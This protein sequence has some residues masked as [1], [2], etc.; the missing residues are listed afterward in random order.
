[1]HMLELVSDP[2][3]VDVKTV[4]VA[5]T[6]LGMKRYETALVDNGVDGAALVALSYDE[7]VTVLGFQEHHAE[8][9]V[10]MIARFSRLVALADGLAVK[11]ALCKMEYSPQYVTELSLAGQTGLGQERDGA[12][13]AA[14]AD[15]LEH[16]AMLNKLSLRGCALGDGSAEL[17]GRLVGRNGAALPNAHRERDGCVQELDLS[18]NQLGYSN[19]AEEGVLALCAAVARQNLLRHLNLGN[20]YIKAV[21]CAALVALLDVDEAARKA[22]ENR[23]KLESLDLTGNRIVTQGAAGLVAAALQYKL[24][25]VLSLGK[26]YVFDTTE[27]DRLRR[28]ALEDDL[29]VN[30]GHEVK[31]KDAEDEQGGPLAIAAAGAGAAS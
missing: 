4:V 20:N 23:S 22:G 1:M 31:K 14:L 19:G 24:L 8:A 3:R 15:G 6:P 16:A 21:G 29:V 25:K 7:L 30:F 17:L 5:L 10:A 2:S 26:N 11:K 12:Q 27:Q 9:L 18:H 28:D 13:L